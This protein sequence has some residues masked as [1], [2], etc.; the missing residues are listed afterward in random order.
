MVLETGSQGTEALETGSQGP[1]AL[2]TGSQGPGILDRRHPEPGV[3]ASQV[4]QVRAKRQQEP[5]VTAT[6]REPG[7]EEQLSS[8]DSGLLGNLREL[9]RNSPYLCDAVSRKPISIEVVLLSSLMS[10]QRQIFPCSPRAPQYLACIQRP[11]RTLCVQ[12]IRDNILQLIC[13][14][15]LKCSYLLVILWKELKKT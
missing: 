11:D 4:G 1:G 14:S 13:L 7:Q 8:E 12:T 5:R 15:S 3:A 2:E 6:Q 10:S 9:T